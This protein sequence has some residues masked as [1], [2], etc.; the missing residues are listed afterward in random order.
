MSAPYSGNKDAV[1]TPSPAPAPRAVPVGQLIADSDGLTSANLYQE[2]KVDKD[3]IAHIQSAVGLD[4]PVLNTGTSG[5]TAVTLSSFGGTV[6]PSGGVHHTDGTRFMI[7]IQTGGAVGVAT[8][9]TSIDGGTTYGAL[10]TTAA[11]MTDAT[12]GITLAFAGTFLAAGTAGFRSAFTPLA[13]WNNQ[14]AKLRSQVDHNGFMIDRVSTFREDWPIAGTAGSAGQMTAIGLY[15]WFALIAGTANVS[16]AS[17]VTPTF[18]SGYCEF[19]VATTSAAKA[20]IS[21][22]MQFFH[23]QSSLVSAVLE[24]E[25]AMDTAGA[26]NQT[27]Q[28]GL[29]AVR[30]MS[31]PSGGYI[32]FSKLSGNTNWQCITNDGATSNSQDSGVAPPAGGPST[33][34]QRFRIEFHG[35]AAPYGAPARV[36]FFINEALVAVSTVNVPNTFLYFSGYV[37][38]TNTTGGLQHGFLGPVRCVSNRWATLSPL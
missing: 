38:N 26:N 6:T 11:S 22:A 30:D 15:Q 4:V 18:P 19:A 7:Q 13:S 9:K 12:S 27:H 35:S 16:V 37:L 5:F 31:S 2:F 3:F 28:I 8:F 1:Q 36:F 10:Q 23:C 25:Y 24:F 21:S 14:A 29:S 32:A 20:G 34:F 33:G 17:T